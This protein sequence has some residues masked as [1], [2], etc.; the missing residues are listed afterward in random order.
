VRIDISSL[1][2]AKAY[3]NFTGKR[4][5]D[6]CSYHASPKFIAPRHIGLTRTDA[7]GLR[8]R[9]LAS[10]VCGGGAGAR[11]MAIE[12]SVKGFF[13]LVWVFCTTIM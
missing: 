4:R 5:K 6:R 3:S 8:I 12:N 1:S 11:D 9:C 7:F 2:E 10:K 13:L